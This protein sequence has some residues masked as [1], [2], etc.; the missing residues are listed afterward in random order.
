MNILLN[1]PFA[2]KDD[3]KKKGAKWNPDIKKWYIDDA[4]KLLGV[5]K[6]LDA[7]NIICENLYLLKKSHICWKCGKTIDVV[8]LA[9]DRSYNMDEQ[10][11]LNTNLQILTYVTQ[12]SEALKKFLQ[13]HR[14]YLSY[15]NTIKESYYIN[16]CEH[17]ES[18]I[19][20]HFL[21]EVPEQA[22]YRKLCYKNSTPISYA[23]IVNK[24]CIPLQARLPYY[25]EVCASLEMTLQHMEMGIENRASLNVNQKL[26]NQLLD[27]SVKENDIEIKNKGVVF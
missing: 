23:K 1:V 18:V 19:G 21:H 24:N 2:E 10:Y 14:Y 27:C 22:F 11:A 7:N 26:I 12:M 9:T 13:E 3:A 17:C 25:N 4:S 6:W 5:S 16:H 15:S 8:L 20:D